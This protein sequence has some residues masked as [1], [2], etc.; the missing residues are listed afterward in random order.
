[1]S[2]TQIV[3]GHNLKFGTELEFFFSANDVTE[4][5]DKNHPSW[6]EDESVREEKGLAEARKFISEKL[7]A[8]GVANI[9]PE[10][11]KTKG[12]EDYQY[13][14]VKPEV[15]QRDDELEEQCR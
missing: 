5:L 3:P 8:A 11:R 2:E 10:D 7:T 6:R 15:L 9:V 4:S 1:M 12:K 14:S 13:L